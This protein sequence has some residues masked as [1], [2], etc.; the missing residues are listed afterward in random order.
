M[1]S[2]K[3]SVFVSYSYSGIATQ[4]VD[5]ARG[6]AVFGMVVSKSQLAFSS[7][8]EAGWKFAK[9]YCGQDPLVYEYNG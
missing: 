8:T 2:L 5:A 4:L 1:Q 3:K 6:S 7:P 9:H